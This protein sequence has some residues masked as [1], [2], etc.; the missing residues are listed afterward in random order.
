MAKRKINILKTWQQN[1]SEM[2]YIEQRESKKKW[3][4]IS[5]LWG[6]FKQPNTH[7]IGVTEGEGLE[8]GTE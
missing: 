4:S 7:V 5:E 8:D 6:S 1:L 2:K 3:K